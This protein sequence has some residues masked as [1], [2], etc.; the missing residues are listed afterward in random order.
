MH[1]GQMKPWEMSMDVCGDG[2]G[3]EEEQEEEGGGGKWG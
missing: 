3:E 1:I 2:K